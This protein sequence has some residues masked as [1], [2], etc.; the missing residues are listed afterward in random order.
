MRIYIFK[1]LQDIPI[2]RCPDIYADQVPID[3]FR[4]G[5]EVESLR[6]H[7]RALISI[8]RGL[9]KESGWIQS[10]YLALDRIEDSSCGHN[11]LVKNLPS[12]GKR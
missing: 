6:N 11:P 1:A 5:S 8:W 7:N 12:H 10:K 3:I 9:E 4:K 2:L